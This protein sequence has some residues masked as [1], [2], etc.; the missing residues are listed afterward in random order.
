MLKQCDIKE[1]LSKLHGQVIVYQLTENM[2]WN[3][4]CPKGREEHIRIHDIWQ[5]V[6]VFQRLL[7]VIGSSCFRI[8]TLLYITTNWHGV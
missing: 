7:V 2:T 3:A 4:G 5:N 1:V 6:N 8:L